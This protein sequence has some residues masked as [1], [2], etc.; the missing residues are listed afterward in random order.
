MVDTGRREMKKRKEME[1]CVGKLCSLIGC[2]RKFLIPSHHLFTTN[3]TVEQR[4]RKLVSLEKGGDLEKAVAQ[5]I[6]QATKFNVERFKH[7]IKI[8]VKMIFKLMS[9]IALFM[10]FLCFGDNNWNL[11]QKQVVNWHLL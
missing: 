7:A 5:L 3:V 10:S 4:K 6:N 1:S 9:C 2:H 8:K 11:C